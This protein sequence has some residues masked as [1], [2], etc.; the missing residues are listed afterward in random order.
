MTNSPSPRTI[1]HVS[2]LLWDKHDEDVRP[3]VLAGAAGAG[4]ATEFEGFIKV[5][6]NLPKM[7]AIVENPKKCPVPSD[8]E[9][10]SQYAIVEA[11]LDQANK[12]IIPSFLTYIGRFKPEFQQWFTTQLKQVH[13]ECTQ[14]TAYTKWASEFGID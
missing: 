2:D 9:V 13:P 7:R 14:T 3:M 4:F 5:V 1:E 10:S 12:K 6:K 11:M 8:T